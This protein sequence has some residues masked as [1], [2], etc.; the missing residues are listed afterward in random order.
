MG[1]NLRKSVRKRKRK[2]KR[3][4]RKRKR[5]KVMPHF[6]LRFGPFCD[7]L[8]F[9][10]R[11]GMGSRVLGPNGPAIGLWA[12]LC[13]HGEGPIWARAHNMGRGPYG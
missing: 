3:K 13:P 8:L 5:K 1:I 7:N 12:S 11:R 4:K 9:P 6:I 2:R 10:A